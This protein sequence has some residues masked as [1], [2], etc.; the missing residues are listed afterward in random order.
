MADWMILD[1]FVYRREDNGFPDEFR[2]QVC[3]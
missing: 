3:C 1:R 2:A